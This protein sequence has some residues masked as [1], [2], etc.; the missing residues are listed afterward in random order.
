ME[1]NNKYSAIENLQKIADEKYVEI[2]RNGQV[3]DLILAI[4][5]FPDLSIKNCV[6][7]I[8]QMPDAKR[9]LTKEEWAYKGRELIE[10]PKYINSLSLC[11]YKPEQDFTDSKGTLYVRGADKL[12]VKLKTMYDVSQ[13][14]GAE[15]PKEIDIEY[16]AKYFDA[17]KQSI[18]FT[19]KGYK[20]EYTNIPEKS[21]IDKDNKVIKVKQGMSIHEII[22]ELID[23][24][25]TVL[26]DSRK[27][28][29]LTSNE[30]KN[31]LDLEHK[32]TVSAI[33]SRYGLEVPNFDFS[34]VQKLSDKDLML[35]RDNLQTVRSVV[36]QFTHNIEN[37]IEYKVRVEENKQ[38]KE[39]EPKENES[40]QENEQELDE[41]DELEPMDNNSSESEVY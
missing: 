8:E 39:Q 23:R 3:K 5:K 34:D 6:L 17:V 16:L 28:E 31:I 30:K 29:G 19:T 15:L 40:Q 24:A 10:S 41:N 38:T 1:E 20:V 22:V 32:A 7:V 26:V 9:V 12:N 35:F 33:Y 2:L 11:L 4:G 36:Y 27:P 21:T 37:S 25:A 14:K 13:T 18:E